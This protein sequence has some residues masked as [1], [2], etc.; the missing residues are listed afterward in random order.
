LLTAN[1]SKLYCLGL[2]CTRVC[3]EEISPLL[4]GFT[5]TMFGSMPSAYEDSIKVQ[6]VQLEII[7]YQIF[8]L[9]WSVLFTI[10]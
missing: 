7:N 2:P 9:I 8:K 3:E 10:I 1:L 6:L 5:A 4:Y